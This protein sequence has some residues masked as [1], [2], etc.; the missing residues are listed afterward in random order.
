MGRMGYAPTSRHAHICTGAHG[1]AVM[2]YMGHAA[3]LPIAPNDVMGRMGHA[4]EGSE[5]CVEGEGLGARGMGRRGHMGQI[6][7]RKKSLP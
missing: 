6:Y 4:H 3:G 1:R 2:G 5:A 7:S